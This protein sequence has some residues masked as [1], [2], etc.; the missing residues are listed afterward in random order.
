M[1]KEEKE[2]GSDARDL[3]Q[4]VQQLTILEQVILIINV[5]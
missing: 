1:I 4:L 2:V 5:T 3:T